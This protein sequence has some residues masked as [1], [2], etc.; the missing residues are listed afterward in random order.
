MSTSRS[1]SW[2]T[3]GAPTS[4]SSSCAR[5]SSGAHPTSTNAVVRSWMRCPNGYSGWRQ[6]RF[7]TTSTSGARARARISA[8]I[9]G[10]NRRPDLLAVSA[11]ALP[12]ELEDLRASV[13]RLAETQIAPHAAAADEREE[14]PWASWEAWRDAG[15][16]GLAFPEE[17]GG[18]GGGIL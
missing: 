5:N 9:S 17:Y 4:S 13:R 16:A 12:A 7:T 8:T 1:H 18:Q 6:P 3:T 11:F 2:A 14:Y 15:F 10:V